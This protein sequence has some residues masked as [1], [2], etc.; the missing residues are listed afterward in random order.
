[1]STLSTV[2][3]RVLV[4]EDDAALAK[5]ERRNLEND[6]FSVETSATVAEALQAVRRQP[7][8]AVIIDVHLP[9]GN[10]LKLL[11][12]LK[13][14]DF[15]GPLLFMTSEENEDVAVA[16]FRGGAKEY[17]LKNLPNLR[18]LARK[19]RAAIESHEEEI[20]KERL[21]SENA[22]LKESLQH[23]DKLATLGTMIAGLAHELNNPLTSVLGLSQL[24]LT[25]DEPG[26]KARADWETIEKSVQRCRTII[27]NLLSISRKKAS[28]RAPSDLAAL[29][30]QCLDLRRY[31]WRVHNIAC[32]EDLPLGQPSFPVD[33]CEFQ[34]IVLNLALNAEQALVARGRQGRIRVSIRV[35]EAGARLA[36]EDDGPGVPPEARDRVFEAFFTTK[37]VGQG[38]GL[39]LSICARIAASY[40]G[41]LR[42]ETP[43]GGGARFI[44][45][46]PRP[47][48]AAPAQSAVEPGRHGGE[49]LRI[50]V[51][52]DEPAILDLLR[53]FL[54]AEGHS[55]TTG[56]NFPAALE[57]LRRE[58]FDLLLSDM[59][60]PG[61]SIQEF[62]RIV[63][64]E[65]FDRRMKLALISGSFQGWE[66]EQLL[67][68]RK[69]PLIQK[70]FNL[71]AIRRMLAEVVTG[72]SSL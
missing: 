22:R 2:S 16:A 9:D 61:M 38:T 18:D 43:T 15:S 32:E 36:V 67:A 48:T 11:V 49:R 19:V 35:D 30:Q 71:A 1:M 13:E 29:V 17:L 62:L 33:P 23:A 56:S 45:E 27:Q 70:P 42:F 47:V 72:Q 28:A 25:V 66:A 5:L 69:I 55:I 65:G 63:S 14:S 53:R 20:E 12:A 68:G 37:P 6:G 58:T 39:G 51:V 3:R 59:M 64:K 4:V 7:P 26:D 34:Q 60:M 40:G 31:E 50:L 24:H 46:L 44:L 21:Q 57:T 8:D 10:G 54:T 52:D 41:L